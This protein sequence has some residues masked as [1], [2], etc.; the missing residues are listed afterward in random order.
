MNPINSNMNVSNPYKKLLAIGITITFFLIA[1]GSVVRTTESGLGCPDWPLCYGQIIPPFEFHALVE[2][3]H[4][5]V[6][7]IIG[8]I[9]SIIVTIAHLKYRHIKYI[10][11]PLRICFI[12]LI[13]QVILGAITVINEL[14]PEI[15]TLHLFVALSI[16]GL[17]IF[18][19]SI[20]K[21]G[22]E[23]NFKSKKVLRIVYISTFLTMITILSGSYLVGS[24]ASAVCPDWPLC[25]STKIPDNILTWTHMAHR[26]IAGGTIIVVLFAARQ[27]WASSRNT[28][29][30]MASMVV[31]VLS[32]IQIFVGAANP[33]LEFSSFARSLHLAIAAAVWGSLIMLLAFSGTNKKQIDYD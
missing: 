20:T 17:L 16:F 23:E 22:N 28:D 9:I 5:F 1:L 2:Y 33:W 29:L 25:L 12:A 32:F 15:V 26:I 10:I 21:E 30:R 24:G 8:L 7:S 13:I 6:A 14:P 3:A 11:I 19:W 27:S 18:V 31:G 4:R